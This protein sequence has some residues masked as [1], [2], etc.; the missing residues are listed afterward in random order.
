M[1]DTNSVVVVTNMNNAINKVTVS[2]YITH[3][4]DSDLIIQLIAPDGTTCTLSQNEGMNGQNFGAN[5]TPDIYRTTFDDAAPTLISQGLAPFLGTFSPD[6]PLSRFI[7][8]SGTN[9]NGPWKLHVSDTVQQDVGTIQCWSLLLTPTV[10]ADGGGE[11]PGADLALAATAQPE[12]VILGANLTYNISVTNIGPSSAKNA[13]VS[14]VLPA[15]VGFVSAT[16]SQGSVVQSGGILTWSLGQLNFSS[17][18][19][20]SVRVLPNTVGLISSSISAF[21]EQPD[22]NLANN[23][24]T[25]FSHISPPASD[26]AVGMTALPNP[27]TVNGPLTYT[28]NITNNGPSSAV[29][30]MVTNVLPISVIPRSPSVSQGSL[31]IS[32]NVV[33]ASLGNLALNGTAT[34]SIP[35]TPTAPGTLLATAT[36]ASAYADLVPG[37]NSVSVTT[38]VGPATDLALTFSGQPSPVIAGNNLTYT[39]TVTNLGPNSASGVVLNGFLPPGLPVISTTTAGDS[40]VT[41]PDNTNLFSVSLGGLAAGDGDV[42]T[43]TIG[44]PDT[45]S[46]LLVTAGAVV[47]GNEFDSNT[48][49]NSATVSTI[50][51]PPFI[52]IIPAGA[53]LTSES[54]PVN[55][56]VDNGETVTVTLRLQNLG[57]VGTSNLFGTLLATGGV[58]PLGTNPPSYGALSPGG[59][60][61]VGRSYT[62][63]ADG[64][65]AGTVTAT[66]HLTDGTLD[67]GNVSFY[68][69]LPNTL[70]FTNLA[71]H[72]HL[73]IRLGHALSIRDYRLGHHR[74]RGPHHHHSFQ[75]LP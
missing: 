46:N 62:F 19:N 6:Q 17:S 56:A 26:L 52:S 10:C 31:V 11:C 4:Y 22:P 35:V 7:G 20:L 5:C 70:T 23:S 68:F 67:L 16:A 47:T 45:A 39:L 13:V 30:V 28:V 32:G 73:R 40:P 54:G 34:I 71:P 29:A 48:T 41:F 14:Q 61:V 59:L 64:P 3:P 75:P 42:I 2:M 15:S 51:A 9:V 69:V 50:I 44:T 21:S 74:D 49:N 43:I 24:A 57:N 58:T 38:V 55:G 37:N 72:Y 33:I 60:S 12:P 1:G 8:K 18:A 65:N 25:I 27:T 36:A 66:L 63:R 53:T